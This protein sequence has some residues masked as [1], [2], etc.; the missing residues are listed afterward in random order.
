M[1]AG[2]LENYY[3]IAKEFNHKNEINGMISGRNKSYKFN[4]NWNLNCKCESMCNL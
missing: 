2:I 3:V 1:C 4:L